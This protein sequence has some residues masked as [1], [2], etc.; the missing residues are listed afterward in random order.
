MK[1]VIFVA[2][3]LQSCTLDS[4]TYDQNSIAFVFSDNQ[5]LFLPLM[6]FKKTFV[7]SDFEQMPE[8]LV[9]FKI[10]NECRDSRNYQ[11]YMTIH[12]HVL[13]NFEIYFNMN[14]TLK[15]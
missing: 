8:K 6:D 4:W 9:V 10:D 3:D 14:K 1:R 2:S 12:D 15:S 11:A 13:N 5:C 7:A